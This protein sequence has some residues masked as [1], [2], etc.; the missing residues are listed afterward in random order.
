MRR[1]HYDRDG[2]GVCDP[3]VCRDVSP[4]GLLCGGVPL[5]AHTPGGDVVRH[6]LSQIGILFDADPDPKTCVPDVVDRP[7][8]DPSAHVPITSD[9]WFSD[10]PDAAQFIQQLFSLTGE[11][12]SPTALPVYYFSMVGA[13][14]AQ[15]RA[16]GYSVDHVPSIDD[17]ID[18]CAVLTSSARIECWARLDQYL[19]S[20]IVPWVPYM[21]PLG[22]WVVSSRVASF[23]V[24]ES[25]GEPRLDRIALE[26][27]SS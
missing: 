17:R 27:G 9:G 13:S 23:A 11:G 1:S 19:M 22:T 3:A 21:E 14:P 24:D 12:T 18:R 7:Q 6:D 16:W 10:Y 25:T 15:L 8:F 26:E 5:P 20:E 4:V 2:D